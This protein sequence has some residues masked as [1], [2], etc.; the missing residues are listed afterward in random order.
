M[1]GTLFYISRTINLFRTV[2]GNGKRTRYCC[3]IR[4]NQF[5]LNCNSQFRLFRQTVST[6]MGAGLGKN[7]RAKKLAKQKER[8]A[9]TRN[10]TS[11]QHTNEKG[12]NNPSF[13]SI[14]SCSRITTLR[15]NH[16]SYHPR[17]KPR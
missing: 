10:K 16:N 8:A 1:I 5:Y 17:L 7:A 14:R 12:P 13:M 2:T 9:G 6:T 11:Y 15:Y 4:L 3:L